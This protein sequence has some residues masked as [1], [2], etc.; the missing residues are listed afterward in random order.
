MLLGVVKGKARWWALRR[1]GVIELCCKDVRDASGRCAVLES[2]EGCFL[3]GNV[4]WFGATEA[5]WRVYLA[6]RSSDAGEEG[7]LLG[8]KPI[9]VCWDTLWSDVVVS[10][11]HK[12][13]LLLILQGSTLKTAE[14]VSDA[15]AYAIV[16]LVLIVF[17][18]GVGYC[19][20]RSKEF[21]LVLR[22]YACS[23]TD[24]SEKQG[25]VVFV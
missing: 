9:V 24:L 21:S 12:G 13:I 6:F 7:C 8:R 22:L 23:V 18:C 19:R 2:N 10:R 20:V 3:P 5:R 1:R 15:R 25:L 17:R 11:I 14:C 16:F 4:V